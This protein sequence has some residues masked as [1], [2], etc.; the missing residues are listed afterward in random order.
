MNLEKPHFKNRNENNRRKNKKEKD[1]Q[2]GGLLNY[3]ENVNDQ[4]H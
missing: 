1:G 3:H 4:I 2:L